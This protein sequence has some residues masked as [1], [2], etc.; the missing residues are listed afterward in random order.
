MDVECADIP[1]KSLFGNKT[2]E[3]SMIWT[4]NFCFCCDQM[5]FFL[6]FIATSKLQQWLWTLF[7]WNIVISFCFPSQGNFQWLRQCTQICFGLEIGNSHAKCL[8]VEVE[9][10]DWPF[11]IWYWLCSQVCC[12]SFGVYQ[13]VCSRRRQ[14]FGSCNLAEH[15]AISC[16]SS[17]KLKLATSVFVF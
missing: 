12:I 4:L 5:L 3:Q 6:V 15:V 14:F 17:R 2:S 9:M 10:M 1:F 8:D 16:A 11:L 13:G 7:S